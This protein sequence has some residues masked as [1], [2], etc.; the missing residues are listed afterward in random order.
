[1]MSEQERRE[2]VKLLF[3][4]RVVEVNVERP[5]VLASGKQSPVYLDHRR[6]FSHVELRRKTVA[7]WRQLLLDEGR[8]R[9]SAETIIAGTASAGI[10]PAYALAEALGCSFVYVRDAAKGH[11]AGRRIEGIW[12]A[13]AKVIIV[14]DMVTT[15]GSLLQAASHLRE[16]GAEVLF[17]TSVSRHDFRAT[18]ANFQS[19]SMPLVSLF[20]TTEIFDAAHGAGLIGSREMRVVMDWM[21]AN[22]V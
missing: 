16:E 22:D 18:R 12:S 11:G 19:Q 9:I 21:A 20:K 8:G 3:A 4:C 17:A 14:D 13:A 10:A 1:M 6:I 7:Q 5:F 2:L 15:G